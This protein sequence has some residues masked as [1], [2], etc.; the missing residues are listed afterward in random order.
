MKTVS[1]GPI[2]IEYI[3]TVL[4][5]GKWVHD[6]REEILETLPIVFTIKEFEDSQCILAKYAER[7]VIDTYTEKIFSKDI[8]KELNSSYGARLFANLGV[9]QIALVVDKLKAN[10]WAKSCFVPLV[11]P[12]DPGPRIP[13]LSALQI[14]LRDDAVQFYATFRSQNAFNSYGNFIGIRALQNMVAEKLEHKAGDIHFFVNFPHIYKSDVDKVKNIV[15]E[16]L[17]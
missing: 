3:S 7:H 12:N 10:P 4:N 6:D 9:N 16:Y 2:W 15:S 5:N 11:I 8:I 14:A 1:I 17:D 13:C